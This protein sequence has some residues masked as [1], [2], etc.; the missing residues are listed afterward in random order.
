MAIQITFLV[1]TTVIQ[2][3]EGK[4]FSLWEIASNIR[5]RKEYTK[6]NILLLHFPLFMCFEPPK[7]TDNGGT[8][9][10]I[11]IRATRQHYNT[12]ADD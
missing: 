7:A 2:I 12:K 3:F 5:G 9:Q 6:P 11:G 1:L 4:L 8:R 10:K